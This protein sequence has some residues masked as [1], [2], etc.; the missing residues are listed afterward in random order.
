M[1]AARVRATLG[2]I[3]HALEEE[4]GRYKAEIKTFSGVY[5]KE[6]KNDLSFEKAKQLAN[7][8]AKSEGRRPRIMIYK[9]GA[10][11]SRSRSKSSGDWLCRFRALTLI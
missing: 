7:Q 11:W 1:E 2:E 10:R 9:N 4:F 8:F 6:I 3:S 5:S